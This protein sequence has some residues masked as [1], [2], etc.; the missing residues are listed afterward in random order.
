MV[1]VEGHFLFLSLFS[2]YFFYI[3]FEC[4]RFLVQHI[5]ASLFSVRYSLFSLTRRNIMY[6]I[7]QD[8]FHI[9]FFGSASSSRE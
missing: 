9:A 5:V 1:V 8:I 4:D 2:T 3:Y 7:P 6:M